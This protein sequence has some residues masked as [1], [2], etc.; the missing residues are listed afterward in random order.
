M[1]SFISNSKRFCAS[2]ILRTLVLQ[3]LTRTLSHASNE[4]V[5][6]LGASSTFIHPSAIV[7]PAAII[8]QGVSIGPFCTVGPSAKIGDACK[9]YTGSHIFGDTELGESC[10]VK[11]G[12]IVGEDLPG[13]TVIGYNNIIGHHSVV[14]VKCQDMK[15]KPGDECYLDVGD[16]NDIREY[17]SIHRS[18]KS[19]DGTVIG[20]S[21]L[22]MGSCHIAHDCKVGNN[23]IFANSTLLAGHVVVEDY[24]HTAGAIVVHQ[25]CH[26]G[27]FSF[28]GG[29]SVVSQDV[30]KYMMVAGDRAELRGLNFEGLRRRGFSAEEIKSMRRAYRKIFMPKDATSGGIEERLIEVVQ[31][32]ELANFPSV[33]S[34]VQSIRDSFE[35]NRRGICKYRHWSGS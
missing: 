29:G 34:M 32:E 24:T 15:Y 26:V 10:I 9:L 22:I 19:S 7:H 23:N 18:S 33:C 27:S 13:R 1:F 16:N 11:T 17:T 28:I 3:R 31:N 12:A 20:H 6:S 21:N 2:P 4:S 8:G 35:E 25:F 14:G 5:V 30:P